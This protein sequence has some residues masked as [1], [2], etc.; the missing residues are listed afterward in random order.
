M[1]VQHVVHAAAPTA[2]NWLPLFVG[3]TVFWFLVGL[4]VGWFVLKQPQWAVKVWAWVKGLFSKKPVTATVVHIT[5]DAVHVNT[6]VV[7]APVTT[8]TVTQPAPAA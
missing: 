8:A 7:S 2:F 1:A 6:P 3:S 5:A 4:V